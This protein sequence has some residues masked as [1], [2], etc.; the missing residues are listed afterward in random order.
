MLCKY[1]S[2]SCNILVLDE[3]TDNLDRYG[4][5]KIISF[6]TEKLSDIN[7]IYIISHRG[8]L[9]IPYDNQLS[10]VKEEDGV[11]RIV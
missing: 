1:L 6:I 3:I 5:E 4:C 2:F 8:E 10:I 11:S 7:S 9:E